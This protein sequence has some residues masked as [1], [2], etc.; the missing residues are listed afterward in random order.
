MEL[1]GKEYMLECQFHLG[2][3]TVKEVVNWKSLKGVT[4]LSI[5]SIGLNAT[6]RERERE[7]ES[8]TCPENL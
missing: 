4:K 3:A 2:S 5:F 6:E 7:R 8:I 1:S